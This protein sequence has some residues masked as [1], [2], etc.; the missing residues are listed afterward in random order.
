MDCSILHDARPHKVEKGR[1]IFG[2]ASG[3]ELSAL[4]V[5]G[6]SILTP[7]FTGWQP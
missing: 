2:G 7:A 5:A 3:V 4:S 1:G 6:G